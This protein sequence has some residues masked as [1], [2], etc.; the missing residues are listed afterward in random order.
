MA[1]KG[2]DIWNS[3]LSSVE[4]DAS[5][6]L[7]GQATEEW[8]KR[9]Q[10]TQQAFPGDDPIMANQRQLMQAGQY[11]GDAAN[12]AAGGVL[13]TLFQG[14]DFVFGEPATADKSK[15]RL[16]AE[17]A[18]RERKALSKWNGAVESIAN[19]TTGF[20]GLGALHKGGALWGVA[21]GAITGATMMD[22]TEERLSNLIQTQP[23]LRNP[24]TE[25]LAAK[26]GDSRAEGRFK[27][28]VESVAMDT[29]ASVAL[30]AAAKVIKLTRSG[31]KVGAELAAKELNDANVQLAAQEAD[32][33]RKSFISDED[34]AA[35]QADLQ[36]RSFQ[37]SG[38]MA[39]DQAPG[40]AKSFGGEVTPPAEVPP[41]LGGRAE[42]LDR[43]MRQ[44]PDTPEVPGAAQVDPQAAQAQGA[45]PFGGGGP[46]EALDREL[47]AQG[48]IPDE[49]PPSAAAGPGAPYTGPNLGPL[50]RDAT[51][52]AD[53]SAS[54]AGGT[55]AVKEGVEQVPGPTGMRAKKPTA[56]DEVTPE[57]VQKS[58]SRMGKD[59]E[60]VA[61]AGNVE[62]ALQDGH[63][64]GAAGTIPWQK[65]HAPGAA[66]QFIADMVDINQS[67]IAARKGGDAD[68]VLR[69]TKVNKLVEQMSGLFEV[70]PQM[71]LGQLR[72]A[73]D[74]ARALTVQMET[75]FRLANSAFIQ[76]YEMLRRIEA[77]N[78]Q[79]HADR[80]AA[81][82]EFRQRTMVA[83]DLYASAKSLL[84]NSGR[85]LR[86][87]REEFQLRGNQMQS[88]EIAKMDPETLARLFRATEGDP[89]AMAK[90]TKPSFIAQAVDG[91]NLFRMANILSGPTTQ[92]VNFVSNAAMLGFRPLTKGMGSYVQSTY[93]AM[94]NNEV[95]A[96]GARATRRQAKVEML[97][98]ASTIADGMQAFKKAFLLGD[99]VMAPH[100]STEAFEALSGGVGGDVRSLPWRDFKTIDDV[101]ANGIKALTYVA[102]AD[103]RL[104]GAAD[105]MVKNMRYRGVLMGR[106]AVE[107]DEAGI[108]VG[109]QAYKDILKQRAQAGFDENG[110][111]IDAHALQEARVTTFQQ[112]LKLAPEDTWGGFQTL[113]ATASQFTNNFPVAKLI[114]PFIKTPS[115]L[116][117][118]GIRLTPGLNLL[119]KEYVNAL[120]GVHG[121]AAQ[122]TAMGEMAMGILLLSAG[123]Q[124]RLADKMTGSGPRDPKQAQQW[125]AAGNMPYAIRTGDDG[126]SFQINRFD[127]LQMPA[128]LAADFVD[129]YLM[130]QNKGD[131]ED[132]ENVATGMVLAIAHQLKDKTYYKGASDFMDALNDEKRVK[133]WSERFAPGFIP[134]VSLLRS[135]NS[136]PYVHE[137]NGVVDSIKANIPGYS[138]QV[139]VRYDV[140]GKPVMVPGKFIGQ[141][142]HESP[143]TKALDEQFAMTGT[144]LSA[145]APRVEGID[146]REVTLAK[147]GNAFEEYNKAV[148]K[149][150]GMKVTLEKALERTVTSPQYT[151]A[152]HGASGDANTKEKMVADVIN[153]Y[154]AAALAQIKM[155]HKDLREALGQKARDNFNKA[156]VGKKDLESVKANATAKG[157]NDLLQSYGGPRA[158]PVPQVL[159]MQQ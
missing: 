139:P 24:M 65:L 143:L 145:P 54:G 69:D 47:R 26:P 118:Y 87:A 93:A 127:P 88:V 104:M 48:V 147:G 82:E 6:E 60:A 46:A 109:S 15:F 49:V 105:E 55:K 125:K 149:P 113:G 56:L 122:A 156:M 35:A 78:L 148:N 67:A 96:A 138:D 159:P 51:D 12:S 126:A 110:R 30:L 119:Q 66:R 57:Q 21:R 144:Y 85:T 157:L 29:V 19:F 64:F 33:Y 37:S 27:N 154:R 77:G 16:D 117:R 73:G 83:V 155:E 10:A 94:T 17:Q 158:V 133:S 44:A 153:S 106:A 141:K 102:T 107:A 91:V 9:E 53:V 36:Q 134:G 58:I 151:A 52:A 101:I 112:D 70:D 136:D 25:Y 142:D 5:A 13:E 124:L 130:H 92:I 121:E 95:M 84:S 23:W 41:G 137:I 28:A 123:V 62:Q 71:I 74:Q 116:F 115:N 75:G 146:L 59:D 79:G 61:A 11:L 22:P 111:A 103:L 20:S 132:L 72:A 89:V 40:M 1:V 18:A 140:L 114:V 2:D 4:Q 90:A 131:M 76:N 120:K 108:K 99:S 3:V 128:A 135:V 50:S 150:M 129:M 152:P 42:A 34:T 68:G 14:K 86:R 98:T 43:E 100:N 38:A 63:K 32:H 39:D 80:A 81:L 8:A 31:D 7:Q 45:A 97:S